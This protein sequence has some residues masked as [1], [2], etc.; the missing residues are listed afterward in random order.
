[1]GSY[2]RSSGLMRSFYRRYSWFS[3]GLNP[4]SGLSF[5]ALDEPSRE[6]VFGQKY[7]SISLIRRRLYFTS[8]RST[9]LPEFIR[10]LETLLL[11]FR[12]FYGLHSR[13]N[14]YPRSLIKFSIC[15]LTVPD[16]WNITVY[17][18][19]TTLLSNSRT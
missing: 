10:I 1:M 2:L 6:L 12:R 4:V 19:C 8:I 7:V 18:T 16:R 13:P 11:N 9:T 5:H 3:L 17:K 14:I 15:H